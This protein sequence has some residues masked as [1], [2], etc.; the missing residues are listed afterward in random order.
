[1]DLDEI[2]DEGKR[3][4]KL[5]IKQRFFSWRD[6]FSIYDENGNVKYYVEGD[7]FSWAKK[8]R[9]YDLE[10]RELAL[11]EEERSAFLQKYRIFRDGNQMALVVKEITFFKHIFSVYGLD[12][13]VRGDFW[14]HEYEIANNEQTIVTISKEWM[15]WGDTYEIRFATAVD[16]V[17]ALAVVLVID[18]CIEEAQNR[19]KEI[20]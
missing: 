13:S 6:K 4:M 14:N 15:T 20:L 11:I 5:Y 18:A 8:L 3:K 1:M 17:A 16:E 9:L 12:W 19:Q 7:V 2:A 10:K